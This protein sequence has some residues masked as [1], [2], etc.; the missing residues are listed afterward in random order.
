MVI[1]INGKLRS[2]LQVPRDLDKEELESLA[3]DNERAR[4]FMEGK[5]IRKI[6]HVPNK[7]VNIVVS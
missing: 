1:Q 4:K 3:T 6:I 7:L 2:E 5:Q